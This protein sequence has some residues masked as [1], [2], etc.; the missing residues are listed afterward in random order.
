MTQS[1]SQ[2]TDRVPGTPSLHP[3]GRGMSALG[4]NMSHYLQKLSPDTKLE[5]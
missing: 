5:L 1:W 2:A 4:S 3:T